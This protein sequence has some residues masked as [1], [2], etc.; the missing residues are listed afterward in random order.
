MTMAT[1]DI[2]YFRDIWAEMGLH[3]AVCE[4]CD[5]PLYRAWDEWE[6]QAAPDAD[7]ETTVT[8]CQECIDDGMEQ[9]GS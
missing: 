8:V 6:T 9:A 2:Q 4:S 3:D 7:G 5:R 1:E